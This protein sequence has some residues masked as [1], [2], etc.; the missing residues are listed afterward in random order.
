MFGLI[1]CRAD[2]LVKRVFTLE[3]FPRRHSYRIL[4]YDMINTVK[5][6]VLDMGSSESESKL[7][8]VYFWVIPCQVNQNIGTFGPDPLGFFSNLAHHKYHRR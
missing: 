1:C 2:E 5:R 6:H 8:M 7:E 4:K 3:Y